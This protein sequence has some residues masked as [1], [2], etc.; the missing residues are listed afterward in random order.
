ASAPVDLSAYAGQTVQI[1]FRFD[2]VDKKNNNFEGWY[3]DDVRIQ[4]ILPHDNYSFTV[5]T[6]QNVTVVLESLTG[7]D[8]NV[9]LQN[10]A[11]TTTLP[12]G[13]RGATNVDQ[14][15]YNFNLPGAGTYNLAITGAVNTAYSLVVV[16]D[17]V[18]DLE[19]NDSSSQ[20][21]DMNGVVGSLGYLE[22][23]TA[24][25]WY[26]V[27]ATSGQTLN[28]VTSTPGDGSGEPS[29]SLNP[30]IEL[31]NS[32][33]KRVATGVALAD[34]RNESIVYK[35]TRGGA[36]RIRISSEGN[37]TGEYFLDPIVSS[38]GEQPRI[39]P[40]SAAAAGS[41]GSQMEMRE[42]DS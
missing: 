9:V 29:N 3:V 25:D 1:R 4:Q 34:G 42:Q 38:T 39:G 20:A 23:T 27:N 16:L 31:Y 40:S 33:G 15:I 36:Y 13:A 12:A 2:T 10:A 18:F 28:F 6:D 11:G 17:A 35:A 7:G 22:T 14:A 32:A 19:A 30:H 41:L 8:I 21:R 5:G 24:S 37:T 26:T